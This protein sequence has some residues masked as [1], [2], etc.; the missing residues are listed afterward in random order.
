M[1]A[2]IGVGVLSALIVAAVKRGEPFGSLVTA[3]VII[4]PLAGILHW[5][6]S[7]VAH[8]MAFRMLAEMRVALYSKFDQLAPAYLVRRRTGD[9]VAMATWW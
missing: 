4:A 5:L 8:D 1:A 7:W 6:E 3:L 9:M 2:L